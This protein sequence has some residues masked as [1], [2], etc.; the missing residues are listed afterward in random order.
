MKLP[1]DTKALTTIIVVLIVMVS[2]SSVIIYSEMNRSSES[3]TSTG[4]QM[5]A[6]ANSEGSGIYISPTVLTEKGGASAFYTDNGDGSYT[7]TTANA[8]A[9]GG[10]IYGT[11][12]AATIQHVQLQQIATMCGLNWTLY[13]EGTTV[14]SDTM[15][16]IGSMNN[17]SKVLANDTLQAGSLWEPQYSKIIADDKFTQLA[18]TNNLFPAHTCC[19]VAGM[20]TYM[21]SH[22]DATERFLAAYVKGMIYV[23][24][25]LDNK[26]SDK[27][28]NLV[29]ICVEKTGGSISEDV[30]KDA[31]DNITYVYAD[32]E[33]GS[34]NELKTDITALYNSLYNAGQLKHSVQDL[35]FNYASQFSNAF[36]EDAYM[37]S[38]ISRLN[39]GDVTLSTGQSATIT[40]ACIAGDIHQIAVH[41]A[42]AMGYFTDYNLTVTMSYADGGPGVAVA[43]QNGT[44][45]FGLLG[46]PPAT[47][48]TINSMLLHA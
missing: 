38:A 5:V 27:Y 47:S 43:L 11:P 37:T 26:S 41:V 36:I 45:Q 33:A 10:I 17:A 22:T 16:Y 8:A 25:A 23:Q 4:Y 18:L 48:T 2:L 14:S 34:L 44:A 24:E 28:T 19:V 30:I 20:E 31:L 13:Q 32:D 15:Y 1:V 12:G 39:A 42:A 35:G 7:V 9:W 46:A 21:S 40:V 29:N 3:D 6:R